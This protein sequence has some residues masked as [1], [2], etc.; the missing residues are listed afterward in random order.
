[1]ILA[2]L[3]LAARSL[4]PIPPPYEEVE[5]AVTN[6]YLT[7]DQDGKLSHP[8]IVATVTDIAS[9][10]A[11]AELADAKASAAAAAAG[12]ATNA[13]NAVA[14]ELSERELVIYRQGYISAFDATVFLSANCTCVITGVKPGAAVSADGSMVCTEITYALTENASGLVPIVKYNDSITVPKA[15]WGAV[16]AMEGPA[17][18]QGAFTAQDGTVYAFQYKVRVWTPVGDTG[19]Y[20]IQINPGDPLGS[21][22]TFEIA[23]GIKDGITRTVTFDGLTLTISGGLITDVKED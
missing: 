12:A 21:G 15:D 23:G 17:A 14:T 6:E 4:N 16:P 20:F 19:F 3:I 22:Y 18:V 10:A 7:I 8:N 1:M 11:K 5:V 2:A 9:S 13:L